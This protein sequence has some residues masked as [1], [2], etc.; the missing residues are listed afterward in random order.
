MPDPAIEHFRLWGTRDEPIRSAVRALHNPGQQMRLRLDRGAQ[1][2]QLVGV[3]TATGNLIGFI[4]RPDAPRIAGRLERGEYAHVTLVRA[5][6][7]KVRPVPTISVQFFVNANDAPRPSELT[8]SSATRTPRVTETE[9]PHPPTRH[10]P[11]QG[12]LITLTFLL[13]LVLAGIAYAWSV[14][15]AA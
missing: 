4:P 14:V 5:S 1:Q 7:A 8:P 13:P 10:A 6:H 3:E 12:C 11:P 9:F 2:H 15:L